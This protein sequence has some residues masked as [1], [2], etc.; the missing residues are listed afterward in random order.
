MLGVGSW[1]LG[2]GNPY[3]NFPSLTSS[4]T[5]GRSRDANHIKSTAFDLT[6]SHS[7]YEEY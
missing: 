6:D 2:L 5:F 7:G 4:A 1:E 3:A